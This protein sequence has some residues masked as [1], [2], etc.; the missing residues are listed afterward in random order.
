[1]I[2][3]RTFL[4]AMFSLPVLRF[5]RRAQAD[6]PVSLLTYS[7]SEGTLDFTPLFDHTGIEYLP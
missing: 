1:M 3:R 5:A 6:L 7:D 4:Q 2:K